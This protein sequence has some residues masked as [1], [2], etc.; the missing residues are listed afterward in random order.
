MGRP[1]GASLL[2]LLGAGVGA[3][4]LA[5]GLEVMNAYVRA[6]AAETAPAAQRLMPDISAEAMRA[7]GPAVAILVPALGMAH[8]LHFQHMASRRRAAAAAA[9]RLYQFDHHGKRP[10]RLEQLVPDYLRAVPMDPFT[11]PVEPIRYLPHADPPVLYSVSKN[12]I[13]DGG[14]TREGQD[15]DL[16]FHLNGPPPQ[17]DGSP[18]PGGVSAR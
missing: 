2:D 8:T 10:E 14:Q 15:A 12:G 5:A 11:E 6:A 7:R 17:G 4:E 1:G 13:D 3:D 16:V 9:I 18:G